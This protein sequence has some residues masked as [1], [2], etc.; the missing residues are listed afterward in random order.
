[1]LCLWL[2]S[3]QS[4]WSSAAGWV[5]GWLLGVG[6]ICG[7]LWQCSL[8]QVVLAGDSR[9][10]IKRG[11]YLVDFGVGVGSPLGVAQIGDVVVIRAGGPWSKS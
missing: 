2:R 10:R 6:K 7:S 4:S 1:M 3:C 5:A 8:F 9:Y 11:P